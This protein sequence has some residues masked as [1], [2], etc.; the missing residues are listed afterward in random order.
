ME[1]ALSRT[2]RLVF[3]MEPT[4]LLRIGFCLH[5]MVSTAVRGMSSAWISSP[6]PPFA[7]PQTHPCCVPV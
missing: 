2:W 1:R 6:T 7:P 5:D 4:R 3:W